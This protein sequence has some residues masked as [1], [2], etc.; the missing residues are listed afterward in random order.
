MKYDLLYADDTLL[1][2]KRASE[3]NIILAAIEKYSSHYKL[4]LNKDKCFCIGMNGKARIHFS[5]GT[6]IKFEDEGAE[7]EV[8]EIKKVKDVDSPTWQE[9]KEHEMTHMPY[10]SW[11]RHC[12]KGRAREVAHVKKRQV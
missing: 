8:T 4:H 11:C 3:I 12:V 2:G 5:D 10:R 7:E 6:P 9:R 1:M